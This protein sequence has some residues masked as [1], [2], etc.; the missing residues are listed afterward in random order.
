LSDRGDICEFSGAWG[1]SALL[2]KARCD[3]VKAIA[4]AEAAVS[5]DDMK[6]PSAEVT[7]MEGNFITMSG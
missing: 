4:Q 7:L 6:D 2:E 1:I 3:H 5:V